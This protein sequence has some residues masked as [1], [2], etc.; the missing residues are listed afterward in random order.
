[1][2]NKLVIIALALSLALGSLWG[3]YTVTHLRNQ[4]EALTEL[5]ARRQDE[6]AALAKEVK[7][8]PEGY[9]L[10]FRTVPTIVSTKRTAGADSDPKEAPA[11]RIMIGWP[12][13]AGLLTMTFW[14]TDWTKG[15]QLDRLPQE[16]VQ[17]ATEY[18]VKDSATWALPWES[19]YLKFSRDSFTLPPGLTG[20]TALEIEEMLLYVPDKDGPCQLYVRHGGYWWQYSTVVRHEDLTTYDR[21]FARSPLVD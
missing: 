18:P 7:S 9:G 12:R 21:H 1:V 4:V 8:R 6:V 20:S 5:A 11:W 16:V 14:G 2:R 19:L 13:L 10:D 17:P 15:R 3:R